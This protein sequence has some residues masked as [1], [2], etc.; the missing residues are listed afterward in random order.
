M[1]YAHISNEYKKSPV[2][3]TL[4]DLQRGVGSILCGDRLFDVGSTLRGIPGFR[5]RILISLHS[6]V[7]R[8]CSIL[9][10]TVLFYPRID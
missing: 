9:N 8:P 10:F 5:G 1:A 6:R 3:F 7:L 4:P 2:G